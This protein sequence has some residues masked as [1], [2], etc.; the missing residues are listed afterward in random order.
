M[1]RYNEYSREEIIEM[2]NKGKE[3]RTRYT[4]E[5]ELFQHES[6][7]MTET[8]FIMIGFN[9]PEYTVPEAKTY[10]RIGEPQKDRYSDLYVPSFNFAEDRREAGVSVVTTSWL[11]SMKSVFFGISNED[12]KAKGV[13]KIEGIEI[14]SVGGD[15]EKLIIPT[16]YAVRTRI[17]TKSGLAK[18]VKEAE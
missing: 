16:A 9:N 17:A 18:A 2:V 5:D 15:D 11:H 14:P 10:Y 6:I 8:R 4:S 1:M 12:L 7:E 3:L 13:W